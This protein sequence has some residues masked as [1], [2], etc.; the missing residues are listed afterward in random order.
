MESLSLVRTLKGELFLFST[1]PSQSAE[2][3]IYDV[4]GEGSG[5][6]FDFGNETWYGVK[7]VAEQTYDG[8]DPDSFWFAQQRI[9]AQCLDLG[10]ELPDYVEI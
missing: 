8:D 10:I 6:P 2:F 5:N 3:S 4:N 1:E 9:I 7:E